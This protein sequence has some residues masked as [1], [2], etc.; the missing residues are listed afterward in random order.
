M[1][2]KKIKGVKNYLYDSI[3]EFHEFGANI[4]VRNNW[5]D[6]EYGEWVF[7]DDMYVCQILKYFKVGKNDC[8]RT[9]CGTFRLNNQKRKMLGSDG[10]AEYIYSFSGKYSKTAD[11]P[12]NSRHFLF[13]KYVARGDD[14]LEAFKKAYPDAK[15]DNYIKQQSAKL[16]KKESIQK[17]VK[18]EVREILDEEG[19]TP[20]YIIQGYKQVSDV[21]ERDADRLRALDSLAKISGLFDTQE[22][23]TE[24]LTVFAGFS[25]E[26]LE[27]ITDKKGLK[28]GK[29]QLL[30]TV[31]RDSEEIQED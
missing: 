2:Y 9:V 31:K 12:D 14:V 22:K 23:K 18:E 10:I 19:A 16:L 24:E 17:M 4:P 5:R 27:S 29:A 30:G 21:S 3:E 26:Q 15:S 6:G 11:M 28:N 20:K 1:E 13:A 8:V 7:T 25:P